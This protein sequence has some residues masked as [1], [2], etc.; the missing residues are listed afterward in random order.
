MM[1][2]NGGSVMV[3]ADDGVLGEPSHRVCALSCKAP[4]AHFLGFAQLACAVICYRR[5]IKLDLLTRNNPK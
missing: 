5:V 2:R 1:M 4:A 3:R